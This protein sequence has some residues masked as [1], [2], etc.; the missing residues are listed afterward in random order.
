M[1]E[2]TYLEFLNTYNN[3]RECLIKCTRFKVL[4]RYINRQSSILR[5]LFPIIVIFQIFWAK[6]NYLSFY[7]SLT[8]QFRT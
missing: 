8:I 5:Y 4:S 6:Q 1:F 3:E 2:V 7:R